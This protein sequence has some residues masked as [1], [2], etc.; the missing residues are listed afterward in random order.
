MDA[1]GGNAERGN[2]MPEPLMMVF[3]NSLGLQ[4]ISM[5]DGKTGIS[6]YLRHGISQAE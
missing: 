4:R 3:R 6:P 1:S 2:E 5:I